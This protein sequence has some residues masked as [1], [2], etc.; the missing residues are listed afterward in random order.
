MEDPPRRQH[1]IARPLIPYRVGRK[2][3]CGNE[4]FLIR[5]LGQ[6]VVGDQLDSIVAVTKPSDFAGQVGKIVHAIKF[7]LSRV[8]AVIIGVAGGKMW[9]HLRSSTIAS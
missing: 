8:G 6:C 4:P 9:E 2:V 7:L 1:W 3:S 5:A